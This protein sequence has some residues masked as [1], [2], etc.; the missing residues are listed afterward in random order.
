MLSQKYERVDVF[1]TS[2][3][4]GATQIAK[5]NIGKYETYVV[6]G[7]DG[8][9][10][11]VINGIA[12]NSNAPNIG[13]IPAGTTNDVAHSL[14]IPRN[15]KKAVKVI[16]REKVFNHDI[17]KV[18]DKYAIYVC[19]T[20][21]GCEASYKTKQ[22]DK[23]FLGK[24]AYFI[25][26]AKKFFQTKPLDL[27]IHFKENDKEV[28]ISNRC[29]LMLIL[30]SRY[31]SGFK[32]N[33]KAVLDDGYVDVV[34]IKNNSLKLNFLSIFTL[35]RLFLFGLDYTKKKKD[36]Y[37]SYYK[38]KEFKIDVENSQDINLDGELGLNGSFDI[39]MI[40]KGVKIFI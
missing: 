1:A 9:L 16:L 8:T 5:E 14:K 26:G 36:K 17:F 38:L 34:L 18:N 7:G 22:K 13:Y 2:L 23:K 32:V 4:K 20:G 39:K 28:S 24:L 35:L 11:E 27:K 21:L 12:E 31:V 3:E 29:S 10:N 37:L 6:A 25:F 19:A 30:N 40:K 33:K 15:I